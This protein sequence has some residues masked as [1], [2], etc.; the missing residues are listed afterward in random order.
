MIFLHHEDEYRI[1]TQ[2]LFIKSKFPYASKFLPAPSLKNEPHFA[3]VN[4]GDKRI[5]LLFLTFQKILA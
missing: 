4:G 1:E 3:H 2:H 5:T